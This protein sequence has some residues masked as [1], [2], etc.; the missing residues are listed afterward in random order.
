MWGSLLS[1]EDLSKRQ[2]IRQTHGANF[3]FDYD[4]SMP[5][6]TISPAL[7]QATDALLKSAMDAIDAAGADWHT[8]MGAQH[9]LLVPGDRVE[10]VQMAMNAWNMASCAPGACERWDLPLAA[11]SQ[12]A[13]VAVEQVFDLPPEFLSQTAEARIPVSVM[14]SH[15]AELQTAQSRWDEAWQPPRIKAPRP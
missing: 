6:T 1:L 2:S 8:E 5:E 4:E 13:Y 10:R 11:A 12:N 15:L 9:T 3:R 7:A 14:G